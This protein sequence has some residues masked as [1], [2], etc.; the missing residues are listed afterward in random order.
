MKS[1]DIEQQLADKLGNREITPSTQAW[2]RIAHNRQFAKSKRKSF[3]GYFVAA[4]I[5]LLF[6]T[7]ALYNTLTVESTLLVPA[8]TVGGA[9][10]KTDE[11]NETRETRASDIV[12]PSTMQRI[13]THENLDEVAALNGSPSKEA[14]A[15]SV[16]S[17]TTSYNKKSELNIAVLPN[18]KDFN[19]DK[20]YTAQADLLLDD[21]MKK[22]AA[23]KFLTT[24]TNDT[25][26]LKEVEQ[27]MDAYY[28]EKAMKI[29]SLKHK[30]IRIA[31]RDKQ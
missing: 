27:E 29:F 25:A 4:A 21:A 23:E 1:R 7:G 26:L 18:A 28:R 6:V 3:I 13:T 16:D 2:S 9:A 20:F 10:G 8:A 22:V 15:I 5:V 14:V 12:T 31:V 24:T 11:K 17:G 30:T 19:L